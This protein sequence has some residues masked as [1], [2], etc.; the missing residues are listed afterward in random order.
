MKLLVTT[1]AMHVVVLWAAAPCV[2]AGEHPSFGGTGL[3]A[4]KMELM[5]AKV[6]AH[7]LHDTFT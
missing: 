1:I 6:C 7:L 4:Q 2:Q 3:A 5:S